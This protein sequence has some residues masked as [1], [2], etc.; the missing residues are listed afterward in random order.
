MCG[1]GSVPNRAE[2]REMTRSKSAKIITAVIALILGL[3]VLIWTSVI[4]SEYSLRCGEKAI[5]DYFADKDVKFI[6]HRG[7]SSKYYENSEDAFVAAAKSKFFY[8]IET[9]VHFTADGV[10]VCSHD[11]DAFEDGNVRITESDYDDIKNMPLKKNSYGYKGKALCTFDKY[12]NICA[13]NGKVAV[14]ELKQSPMSE[15]QIETV[16]EKAKDV[17]GENFVIISFSRKSIETVR[18]I[19][20]T[21]VTQH[22]VSDNESL[23]AALKDGYNV[24]DYFRRMNKAVVDEA[25]GRGRKVGVWTV[26]NINEVM[27]LANYRVDF[28]TTDYDFLSTHYV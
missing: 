26:N 14:I 6:A 20:E 3:G 28:I 5:S 11:N 24:S 10:A 12:L 25:H 23:G 2:V 1:R 21:V 8:G 15:E 7:L 18:S 19:D 13:K 17:C 16:V 9:D 4:A 27:K 22:L